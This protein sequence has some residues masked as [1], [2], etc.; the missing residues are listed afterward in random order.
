VDDQEDYVLTM[1]SL[2]ELE[3][4]EISSALSGEACL[5]ILK[6][7]YFDLI[8]LDFYMPGGMTGED[9]VKALRE[10]NPYVQIVL[11]TGYSGELPP[12][13]MF[14]RLDIQ[15]YHDKADGP[16]RLLLWVDVG[17]RASYMVQLL[18][19]SR[20]GL[21]YILDVTPDLHKIQPVEELLQGILLQVSGLMGVVSAFL[22]VMPEGRL[23]GFEEAGVDGFLAMYGDG[24]ELRIKAATGKFAGLE[25]YEGTLAEEGRQAIDEALHARQ[26]R[27]LGGCSVMPLAIGDTTLG[28]IYVEKRLEQSE[29]LELLKIF[30]NQAAVAI[31]NS[32]LYEMATIDTLTGVFTRRFF[33]Q[34]LVRELRTTFRVKQRLSVL[35]IDMDRFK[36]INDRAGH[37]AGDQALATMGGVLRKATRS[38]DIVARYGGDEFIVLLP[39]TPLERARIVA[40]RIL[41]F[42]ALASVPGPEGKLPLEVS[43]GMVDIDG[44]LFP[45]EG[46]PIP[47]PQS[48]YE[49]MAELLVARADAAMYEAKRQSGSRLRAGDCVGWLPF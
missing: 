1:K 19:K 20:Q 43:I 38:A 2:L 45:A 22:A 39:L 15:G 7:E 30:A 46:V 18:N 24:S 28:I 17:L 13:E 5:E 10:V 29:D 42:L 33:E 26:A 14:R 34:W 9:V 44:A 4:H 21:R 40:D 12:R 25:S 16:E 49:K 32:R 48:Y 41:E 8:L 36:D 37:L 11:Q 47:V 23:R 35:M 27:L 31:Q 3:G 6:K